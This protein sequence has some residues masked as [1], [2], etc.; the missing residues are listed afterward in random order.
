MPEPPNRQPPPQQKVATPPP[1]QGQGSHHGH[2]QRSQEREP[3]SPHDREMFD[4]DAAVRE[5]FALRVKLSKNYPDEFEL[6]AAHDI[7]SAPGLGLSSYH[8]GVVPP[9]PRRTETEPYLPGR[10]QDHYDHQ[11]EKLPHGRS[12]PLGAA[13]RQGYG[14][15]RPAFSKAHTTRDEMLM[16]HETMPSLP[17]EQADAVD[18]DAQVEQ[19][20]RRAHNRL[21]SRRW[22]DRRNLRRQMDRVCR[23]SILDAAAFFESDF[24]AHQS[25][26]DGILRTPHFPPQPLIADDSKPLGNIFD[27]D[28]FEN[29]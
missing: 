28:E 4:A 10:S 13:S 12:A 14:N 29:N 24:V 23:D 6:P 16:E 18:P 11:G 8:R 20:A 22:K 17:S 2:D 1:R 5:I 25:S 9:P 3:A 15:N 21:R 26:R 7:P 19:D 27:G